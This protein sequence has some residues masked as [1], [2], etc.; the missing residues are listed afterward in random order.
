MPVILGH[1]FSAR[2]VAL[3][4]GVTTP[5]PGSLVAVMP[6]VGCDHCDACR[7][8]EPLLCPDKAWTGLST[9]TGGLGD[10]ALVRAN[11]AIPAVGLTSVQAAVVEPAAVALEALVRAKVDSGAT[12]LVIGA[13]PIGALAILGSRALGATHVYVSDPQPWRQAKAVELGGEAVA[14]ASVVD[15]SVDVA[16][17]CAGKPGSIDQA[18]RSLRHGG[19]VVVPAVHPEPRRLDLWRVTRRML[20]IT[21]SLGYTDA[22]F[23]HVID[24]V[25]AG[26]LPVER[27]VTRRSTRDAIVEAGFEAMQPGRAEGLK[28]LI[29][30]AGD[31]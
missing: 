19:T 18:I 26:Q 29:E 10:L 13:G 12:V 6:L 7:R 27:I 20:T 16:V 11:Q 2:V 9:Q 4:P 31:G 25:A 24:L 1:E 3:G 8:G 17:D 15:L 30:V 23:R 5:P 14:D 21:G 22:T 28:T